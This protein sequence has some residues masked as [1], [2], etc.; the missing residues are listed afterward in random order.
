M[1]VLILDWA[2][3]RGAGPARAGGKGWQLGL[4]ADLG[5]PVPEGFVVDAALSQG[6]R[7]GDPLPELLVRALSAELERRAWSDRPLAVR[8]SA[9]MEDSAHASFAGIFTSC[10]NVRGLDAVV[11]AVQEVSD[12]VW[13]PAARAYMQR[14]KL[15]ADETP[16]AVVVM[17][18]LPAVA[19]G[20]AFTCDP[21]TGREDQMVI[22]A[23]WGLGEALVDGKTEGDE[24]RLEEDRTSG[25]TLRLIEQRCGSKSHRSEVSPNGGTELRPTPGDLASR[26][27][28]SSE[29]AIALGTLL[30]DVAAAL[31]YTT[32]FYDV[33]WVWDGS[34]FWI[35]QARPITA[36]S[37]RTYPA[38]EKQPSY[39]SRG[40]SRDVM[41]EPLSPLDWS[42]AHNLNHMLT[43]TAEAGGY[44]P[45][46][47]A[48]RVA[49]RQGR[50][51]FESSI[52]QWEA[53]DGFDV[54]PKAYN[55]LLG[56]H[57]PQIVVPRSTIRERLVRAQR[58][59]RFLLG[60]IRPR[61]H[62]RDLFDQT[63]QWATEQRSRPMPTDDVE[64]GRQLRERAVG[65]RTADD[66]FL[67]Q[68]AGN[69]LYLLLDLLERYFPGE[70]QALTAALLAGG[71]PSVTAAQAY[72]LMQLAEI[73][74]ADEDAL[75]WLR[76]AS[77]VGT[78]WD[79][80]PAT[81]PFRQAFANFMQRYGHRAVYE[82]YLRNPR[83]REAPDYLLDSVVNLIGTDLKR[84]RARQKELTEGAQQRMNEGLPVRYRPV[85]PL[86]VKFATAERNIRES[87]RSAL[88]AHFDVVRRL[89]LE[90]GSRL[91]GPSGLA[92]SGDVFNLTLLE[93]IALVEGRLSPSVA[94]RRAAWRQSQLERYAAATAPEVIVEHG[95]VAMQELALSAESPDGADP[96]RWRGTV[97]GS[98]ITQ[99]EVHIA[100]NPKEA[101][102]LPS[103]AILVAP[104]TDPSWT[105]VFLK[106]AGLVMETGGYMSHGAIVAREFGIPAVVNLP[107]I[108]ERVRSGDRL[109]VDGNRGIV[110]RLP[111]VHG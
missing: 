56:G 103:G 83:W 101:L 50:L 62:A 107:G 41:P 68:S 33:E 67:L 1:T 45:M 21:V 23:N 7:C 24:Y 14:L 65:I 110:R 102:G 77:R 10:L 78:E 4:L 19:A 60:C 74:A 72:E 49:L 111:N 100:H 75:A 13:T 79:R 109:E 64:L 59:V 66:L 61:L 82:S 73:A 71:E 18:L 5:M 35:V 53:F 69:V 97:V 105:P 90:L 17:P 8:S 25:T 99:G 20:V 96:D 48:Q 31:D 12:S 28:L 3:A 57:Q 46:P 38:L 70:G 88:I 15:C 52:L 26:Q 81:S 11:R 9:C 84:V 92:G 58:S 76:S 27:V 39:W 34:G 93:L 47:G 54:Q 29:Q 106:A 37:R 95:E 89:A 94:A 63:H 98:G 55:Q 91:T 30:Q 22:H 40:N 6:R 16:I 87:A 2:A 42:L 51:Y 85:V 86:L 104:S 36:R 32:P 80:L 43:L 108:L 44:T